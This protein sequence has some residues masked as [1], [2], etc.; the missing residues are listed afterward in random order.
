MPTSLTRRKAA[1]KAFSYALVCLGALTVVA[2]ATAWDSADPI[3]Y[4]F[5]LALA[6]LSAGW[7][8][9]LPAFPGTVSV[10]SIFIL[11]GIADFS[12]VET[13]GIGGAA[14]LVQTFFD[15]RERITFG[16]IGFR[17]CNLAVAIAVAHH[18]YRAAHNGTAGAALWAM[19]PAAVLFGLMNTLPAAAIQA[20]SE[21]TG[22]LAVWHECGYWTLPHYLLGG[23]I[24]A[25]ISTL[26]AW[27]GW[28]Y[29][30]P[31]L[32]LIYPL[33]QR[34]H[35]HLEAM[36]V[37]RVGADI[38]ASRH[39]RT[40]EALALAI[41]ARFRAAG[42]HLSRIQTYA[43]VIAD[44]LEISASDREALRIASLL[45]DVGTLAVPEQ[46]ICKT[47]R[48]S[49]EEFEKV[50]VHP[51][52][53]A[54]IIER[55]EFPFPVAEIVRGHHERWDG[56]GYPDGLTGPKIHIGARILSVVDCLVALSSD[57]PDRPAIPFDRALAFVASQAG[58]A[59]DPVVVDIINRKAREFAQ[60]AASA[61]TGV[62]SQDFLFSIST[63]RRESQVV[64]ELAQEIGQS[65]SLAEILAA[66]SQRLRS[67]I[68]YDAMAIFLRRNDLLVVEFASGL[69]QT[70]LKQVQAR[71][72][73]G[74]IGG[75]ARSRQPVVNAEPGRELSSPHLVG[76][77]AVLAIPLEGS[78]GVLAVLA[79]YRKQ[80]NSFTSRELHS[81]K[82]IR[83]VAAG[84]LENAI[85][86]ER[87]EAS[88]TTDYLTGLPNSR[89]LFERLTAELA[90]CQRDDTTV[91]VLVGDLD[92]FKQV[93]DGFGHLA[94]NRVLREVAEALQ[95]SCREYDYVARMGGDEF[96]VL[97]P[98][99]SGGAVDARI[100][101]FREVVATAA[102]KACPTC[103]VGF[104]VGRAR[105]PQDGTDAETLL[106]AADSRMYH[107][108]QARRS[109]V[110]K[111]Y[112]FDWRAYEPAPARPEDHVSV[113]ST[114]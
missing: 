42:D 20:F 39:N 113:A 25:G 9:A 82:G 29:V 79:L 75:V 55:A 73:E 64:Y 6:T 23:T 40:M 98:G 5:C 57:R 44:E 97:L 47:G 51:V 67:M 52:V 15:R 74:A 105:F 95:K 104:S 54:S 81:L 33:Y 38:I 18:V 62:P 17:L 102:S 60:M 109:D 30:F 84:A 10:A 78:D 106:A 93:N 14:L 110:R 77:K 7:R 34:A 35:A 96:V 3:R 108:K 46:I 72:G 112:D 80:K 94:G 26:S 111:G 37:T 88:A 69:G 13:L 4:S 66:L 70:A 103:A 21:R 114:S 19:I 59:F 50:K 48:L 49:S 43:L 91:T 56:K 2:G 1:V 76:L 27:A 100:Q 85:R 36:R 32:A 11:I 90:R 89:S 71:L 63:A 16:A 28:Q 31:A 83:T 101:T 24:A 87:A 92:G 53:G 107:I 68:P 58:T 65:L 99:L 12:L 41:A 86:F 45:H 61:Q 8:V 22:V